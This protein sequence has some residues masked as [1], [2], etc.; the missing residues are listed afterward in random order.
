M[1][2]PALSLHNLTTMHEERTS[3]PP[4]A[5]PSQGMRAQ[6]GYPSSAG[7]H[8]ARNDPGQYS[9]PPVVVPPSPPA[10]P[11]ELRERRALPQ[12]GSGGRLNIQDLLR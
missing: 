12:P 1:E 4:Q 11:E 7:P 3:M 6:Q 10:V 8:L 5:M 9:V 2:A